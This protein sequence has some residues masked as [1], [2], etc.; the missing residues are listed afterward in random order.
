M[1]RKKRK[2]RKLITILIAILIVLLIII[3]VFLIKEKNE[4]IPEEMITK[5]Y[6]GKDLDE[7]M[8][9]MLN[10]MQSKVD[11]SKMMGSINVTV[12]NRQI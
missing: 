12:K 9:N 4:K 8:K 3:A 6:K 10:D 2:I 11:L 5:Q 7:V 1:K